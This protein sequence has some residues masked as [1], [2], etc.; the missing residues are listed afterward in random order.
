M[1]KT[2]LIIIGAGPGGYETAVRA[3]KAGLNTVIIEADKVGGTCLNVGCIP[4]K[5]FCRNAE[6][7]RNLKEADVLGVENVS[8]TFN[9]QKVVERKNQVVA[10]LSAGIETLLKQPL[11]TFVKGKA[12]FTG[13]HSIHVENACNING[14]NVDNDFEADHI[15]IATGSVTKFL[16]IPGKDL[17][18]VLTSTEMLNLTEIPSK[19]CVIGGGVIGMEFASIFNA[20][21]SEVTVLEFCKEILPNIDSDITKRLKASFKSQGINIINNAAVNCIEDKGCCYSVG[22]EL[23]GTQQS[24]DADIVLM[25]VGRGANTSSLGLE[26]AGIETDRRGIITND[27]FETNVSGVYAIGDVNGKCQ[28]AHAASFQGFHTLNHILG[29]EDEIRFDIIPAAVFTYP[30]AAM[31]GVTSDYCK[32]NGIGCTAHKGFFRANGKALAMNE[33]DGMVKI[34]TDENDTIIGASLFGPHAADLIQE[35]AALMN[36]NAK[37]SDLAQIVHAHPTLGEVVMNAAEA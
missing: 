14:E 15:I 12:T 37:L 1:I 2:D 36:K 4:T 29:K 26:N 6:L 34:L 9:M 35:I 19:L 10:T 22:Y 28:L 24:V 33:T 25:A 16:P 21:G 23:K 17:P 8:Y 27:D 13:K 11:I 20:F 7:L 5:S 18:K 32:Q 30:E 31:V 3:A